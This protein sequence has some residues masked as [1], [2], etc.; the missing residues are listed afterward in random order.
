MAL[1]DCSASLP[2]VE[3]GT[4]EFN[5]VGALHS[6][7]WLHGGDAAAALLDGCDSRLPSPEEFRARVLLFVSGAVLF[8]WRITARSECADSL[9]RSAA[10]AASICRSAA[11]HRAVL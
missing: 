11:V 7:D 3:S 5:G 6:A 4:M 8:L 9:P 2:S 1:G 10:R